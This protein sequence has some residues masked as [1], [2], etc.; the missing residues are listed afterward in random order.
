MKTQNTRIK[1]ALTLVL[2][3]AGLALTGC[4]SSSS[5]GA[6]STYNPGINTCIGANCYIINPTPLNKSFYAQTSNM[7]GV[8]AN[9]G[10]S[11]NVVNSN[12]SLIKLLGEA[13]GVCDRGYY[14]GGLADCNTWMNGIYDL[15]FMVDAYDANKVNIIFRA[16]PNVGQSW[17]TYNLPRWDQFFM[18][19]MGMPIATNPQG[20]FNPLILQ[21]TIH[22]IVNSQGFEIRAYGPQGSQGYNKA[23]QIQVASGKVE[24]ERFGYNMFWN[25]DTVASG[26]LVRCQT[27]TCG[28]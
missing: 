11:F 17:Y 19:L 18:S 6:N 12:S 16:Y 5:G 15:V 21:G 14:N 2:F 28:L 9:N 23:I 4:G 1:Q 24:D 27:P 26:T 3:V 10:S 25:G 20:V 7:N 13:M 8:F 22:P